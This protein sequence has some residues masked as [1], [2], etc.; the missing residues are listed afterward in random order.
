MLKLVG[1][2]DAQRKRKPAIHTVESYNH[3]HELLE[4]YL[5]SHVIRNHSEKTIEGERRFLVSWFREHGSGTTPLFTWQAMEPVIGR[6]RVL[7]YANSLIEGGLSSDT[8][9]RYL[10]ILSRYFAYVLEHPHLL[11]RDASSLKYIRIQDLY[12]FIDQP[13][14]EYDI[15]VHAY[16]GERLGVPLDPERLY[17]FYA[18]LRSQYLTASSRLSVRARNYAMAVLA[19][20]TG[21]RADELLHLEIQDL[22]FD[23]KKVQTRY[24]KGTKGSGKRAR[25]TLFPPLARD[26]I[27]YYLKEHRPRLSGAKDSTLLF[28]SQSGGSLSYSIIRQALA[29]MIESA[30][31]AKVP[32][33]PHMSWHWFRRIFATR[34]IE[35][36]PNQLSVLVTLLGHMSPNTVH[37][38]I[39]HSEA[40]MDQRIQSVLEGVDPI[41]VSTGN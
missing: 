5:G 10:G 23:S 39:R 27:R 13:V 31:R 33:L 41:W 24:A 12:G 19:G 18:V 3:H 9:R 25:L 6:K 30:S 36:F 26:T 15:P 29:E 32:V 28:P 8:V 11:N 37:R 14:S 1:A 17:D 21:L 34:F 20:E 38:Y 7:G 35:R 2:G 40:W 22:F 4:G 16:D